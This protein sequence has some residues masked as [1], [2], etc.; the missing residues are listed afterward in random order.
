MVQ[1]DGVRKKYH[2]C[3]NHN[4]WTLHSPAECK[5]N[6]MYVSKKRKQSRD[7]QQD[8]KPKSQTIEDL[9]VA[10]QALANSLQ[11][12]DSNTSDTIASNNTWHSSNGQD[13]IG[14]ETDES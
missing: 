4:A 13:A 3:V 10:F 5:R 12:T 6:G 8:K 14:Y 1:V 9:Q 11:D 2:W 7:I